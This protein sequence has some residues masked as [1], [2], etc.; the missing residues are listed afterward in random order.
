MS[1][2]IQ[3][4]LVAAALLS[5]SAEGDAAST[6]LSGSV[7]SISLHPAR[8]GDSSKRTTTGALPPDGSVTIRGKGGNTTFA[9]GEPPGSPPTMICK[10]IP[11]AA[12]ALLGQA[13]VARRRVTVHWYSRP[14]L[15]CIEKL[16]F[17]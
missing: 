10:S 16:S 11:D 4:A 3:L 9:F 12:V 6:R 17:R 14:G 5:A 2:W 7:T 1:R 13:M 15:K 8:T